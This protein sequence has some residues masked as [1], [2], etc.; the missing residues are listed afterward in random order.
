M[1]K[2]V[3]IIALVALMGCDGTECGE[4]TTLIDGV[5]EPDD[6]AGGGD[7][8]LVECGDGTTLVDDICQADVTTDDLV[9]CGPGTVLDSATGECV[10]TVEC[11]PGTEL[12][13]ATGDCIT[14]VDCGPGTVLDSATGDCITSVDCGPGTVL[15]SATGDCITSVDCAA[16]TVLDATSGDCVLDCVAPEVELAGA[17][18]TPQEAL[19]ATATG[20]T[21]EPDDPS[22]SGG[23]ANTLTL[24]TV[25]SSVVVTGT[26]DV[27]AD[28]DGDPTTLEQDFDV[29]EFTGAP[30]DYIDVSV[31]SLG[32]REVSVE[33]TG[34]SGYRRSSPYYAGS[35][36]QREVVLPYAGQ[37]FMTVS[38]TTSFVGIGPPLVG[39]DY[40]LSVEAKTFPSF[41]TL[42]LGTSHVG[43][44]TDQVG[45]FFEV[46]GSADKVL[47][48]ALTDV[49][50]F[51]YPEL[52]IFD[53][54]GALVDV[55]SESLFTLDQGSEDL[56]ILVDY[57][58]L[59]GVDDAYTLAVNELSFIDLGVIP[60]DD[61]LGPVP[62]VPVP[63]ANDE[64]AFFSVD[65]GAGQVVRTG[66]ASVSGS[67]Y[68]IPVITA[69]GGY[70]ANPSED[71]FYCPVA[72]TYIIE[73][74]NPDASDE[75]Q[76]GFES[77][78]AT[79]LG[80]IDLSS[81]DLT[82][83]IPFLIGYEA[84]WFHFT[85][86][87][88]ASIQISSMQGGP[89]SQLGGAAYGAPAM[90]WLEWSDFFR[91]ELD[92]ALPIVRA[93][94][95]VLFQIENVDGF[96][97]GNIQ[98]AVMASTPP[99]LEI[100][101]ND[102]AGTGQPVTP[103]T[104]IIGEAVMGDRDFYE[105][106]ALVPQL[107]LMAALP[108]GAFFE[109]PAL[110]LELNGDILQTNG[111]GP[112]LVAAVLDPTLTYDLQVAN[113][114][115]T[116]GPP[117]TY[118]LSVNPLLAAGTLELEPN[119]DRG[120]TPVSF[121]MTLPDTVIGT[122]AGPAD[123]DFFLLNLATPSPVG[124]TLDLIDLGDG[125]TQSAG[126]LTVEILDN[127]GAVVGDLSS[128]ASL[129]AGDNY[130][131]VSGFD[132]N[133]GNTYQLTA[134]RIVPG[135]VNQVISDSVP[136]TIENTINMPGSCLAGGVDVDVDI[137]HAW[138]GDLRIEL[139]HPTL[140]TFVLAYE[141]TGDSVPNIQGNY[142]N[143][144]PMT[145]GDSLDPMLGVDL[146][147]DWTLR[148]IDTY[149]S[150]DGGIWQTWTLNAICG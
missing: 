58:E 51:V 119:N 32:G 54:A 40:V 114:S 18:V 84:A 13:T 4:G 33:I 104:D 79:D 100:E 109:P 148:V 93:G 85:V 72:G 101:P 6:G 21:T 68:P 140:G 115:D 30:G 70:L 113:M 12:D 139:D 134:F 24:P 28:L 130:V 83:T 2:A 34:P 122:L 47:E 20:T 137:L 53:S 39:P 46:S 88:D 145:L 138:R 35:T 103:G 43:G 117:L 106:D 64:T 67:G 44:T 120:T 50:P 62:A 73:L 14:S 66:V 127:S 22:F 125:E 48:V 146:Q 150:S 147:G 123:E 82:D 77:V 71:F 10:T 111:F 105:V 63:I 121:A 65:C 136:T 87:E 126:N 92:I 149:P 80:S 116:F 78:T 3:S 29:W 36:S 94:D 55:R 17:C 98:V 7:E 45:S 142:P 90:N 23:T 81:G 59:Q 135:V 99:V 110:T 76:F 108:Q 144:W 91:S 118:T 41:N 107:Y 74:Y 19:A 69:P 86:D 11:G 89:F 102:S 133:G 1:R 42:A 8:D 27:P 124:V 5:C 57:V 25:G 75:F 112:P 31:S 128:P 9:D 96:D 49:A 129:A 26:V 15:D 61:S 38:N 16:G 95:S 143:S 37:Y 131:R 97:A 52:M 60:I 141:D 56:R 132:G